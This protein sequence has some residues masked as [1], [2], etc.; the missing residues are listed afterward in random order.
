MIRAATPVLRNRLLCGAL[1]LLG[2][3]GGGPAKAA[4]EDPQLPGD[5]VTSVVGEI[6]LHQFP[7]GAHGWATFI[8][9]PVPLAELHGAELVHLGHAESALGQKTLQILGRLRLHLAAQK[10]QAGRPTQRQARRVHLPT[11]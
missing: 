10:A 8:E 4:T 9:P 3:C 6:H 7:L 1:L 5:S 11:A 2:A